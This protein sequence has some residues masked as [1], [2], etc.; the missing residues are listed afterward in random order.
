MQPFHFDLED[1]GRLGLL[2]LNRGRWRNEEIIPQWFV[3]A[4]ES[5]Q[6]D[7]IGVNYNGPD[8]GKIN[9][10]P[11]R[12]PEAPYGF[13]TWV[14]TDGDFYPGADRAWAWAAGAGGARVLWNRNNGI[15]FAAFGA[16][17]GPSDNGIPHVIERSI[18]FTL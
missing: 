16:D 2:I 6:T 18:L 9:L 4:L 15:V 1:M 13:M 11:K 7:G 12:F 14:N 8:D 10:D 3:E 17:K 5:K